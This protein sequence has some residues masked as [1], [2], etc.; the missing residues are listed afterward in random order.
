MFWFV[1]GV[2][3][4]K[5]G[6]RAEEEE[7]YKRAIALNANYYDA[8][9]NLGAMYF[10]DGLEKEKVCNEIP[11]REKAKFDECQA[12]SKVMFANSV[13]SLEAAYNLKSSEKEIIAALKDAYYK[14]GNT[15]GYNRMKELLGMGTVNKSNYDRISVGMSY[16]EVRSFMGDGSNSAESENVIIYSWKGSSA[17]I[18]VVVENGKVKSKSQSGF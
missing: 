5:L 3:Y 8:L 17:V 6:K 12:A 14:N 1:L 15:D 2:T 11:P 4:E 13:Q 18:S 16:S 9:F 10:N 7:A